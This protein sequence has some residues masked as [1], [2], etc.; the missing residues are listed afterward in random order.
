MEKQGLNRRN[1][2]QVLLVDDHPSVRYGIAVALRGIQDLAICEAKGSGREALGV[3]ERLLPDIVVSDISLGDTHGLDLISE[4]H[5][6]YPSV[7]LLVFSRYHERVYAER[8][9]RAG[10][11]GY[12]MKSAPTSLLVDAI[13][14]VA[15]GEIWLSREV[16]SRILGKLLMGPNA[17]V[18]YVTDAL[19]DREL[20]VFQMLGE[21]YSITDIMDRL[22][23][24]RKT[25][26]TYRRR[27][28]EKFNCRTVRDLLKYAEEWTY[29]AAAV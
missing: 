15:R 16:A 13:R 3:I 9:F 2:I 19:T 7:N 18:P 14:T 17:S 8:A 6:R 10:A 12:L 23:I 27:A 11:S 25:A 22:H 5:S 21:G 1:P 29:N 28:K 20:I 4:V 24:S 26:E